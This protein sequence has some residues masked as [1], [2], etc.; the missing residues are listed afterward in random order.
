L[1]AAIGCT[2]GL[3]ASCLDFKDPHP[4]LPGQSRALDEACRNGRCT[5]SGSAVITSGPT[6]DTLGIKMGPGPSTAS[7][8]VSGASD[9]PPDY[10]WHIELLV[11]G[12]GPFS[13]YEPACATVNTPQNRP[14]QAPAG[15]RWIAPFSCTIHPRS[16]TTGTVMISGTEGSVMDIADVRIVGEHV[17]DGCSVTRSRRIVR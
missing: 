5:L 1:L 9:L 15:Y 4:P 3:D 12:A 2:F 17:S 8:A 7:I 10:V 11:S 14:F 6:P 13:A 16:D